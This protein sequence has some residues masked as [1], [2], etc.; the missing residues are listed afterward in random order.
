[1]GMPCVFFNLRPNAPSMPRNS[2]D[3][4]IVCNQATSFQKADFC[5]GV[6]LR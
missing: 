3:G 4:Q 1:L 5:A 2:R 6:S